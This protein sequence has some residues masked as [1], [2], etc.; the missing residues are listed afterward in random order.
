[1]MYELPMR[2]FRDLAVWQKS[3]SVVVSVYHLTDLYPRSER[4]G[5]VQQ[6]RRAAVSIGANIA[7]GFGRYGHREFARFL[8]IALGSESELESHLEMAAALEYVDDVPL[9][10]LIS[11]CGEL[12]GML[13]RFSRGLTNEREGKGQEG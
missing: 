10:E 4:F 1:M 8:A 5:L 6:T 9:K 12:R 2:D 11:E 3:R 7:E 13:I